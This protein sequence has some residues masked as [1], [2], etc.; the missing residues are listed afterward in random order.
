MWFLVL[1]LY[2]VKIIK[3][4]FETHL[5]VNNQVK[6]IYTVLV[7][8]QQTF[9]SHGGLWTVET[10]VD[11]EIRRLTELVLTPCHRTPLSYWGEQVKGDGW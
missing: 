1:V 10:R 11:F 3:A 9:E 7:I 8:S 2:C 4:L 5:I 6:A